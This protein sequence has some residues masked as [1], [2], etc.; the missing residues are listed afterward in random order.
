MYEAVLGE[1]TLVGEHF[2]TLLT[3]VVLDAG[4]D[5]G[6]LGQVALVCEKFTTFLTFEVLNSSV[7]K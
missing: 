4:M 7:E 6:V 3:V 1:V 2:T 5:Q